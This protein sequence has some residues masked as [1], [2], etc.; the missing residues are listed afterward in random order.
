MFVFV[1]GTLQGGCN[2]NGILRRSKFVS[3][4]VVRGYE[5]YDSG[6][7]V[8]NKSEGT[9]VKGEVWDIGDPE[10]DAVA[11]ATLYNLDSLEG[12]HEHNLEGSMYHR[13]EVLAHAEDGTDYKAGMYLGNK[14]FWRDFFGMRHCP[15][16]D[17]NKTFEW[18]RH[19]RG[20]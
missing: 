5:L 10:T 11:A 7:P 15:Y 3:P 17:A 16:D 19:G 1:Y 18:A 8:A 12:Y 13:V 6:F 20:W 14:H 9:C 2:N 4:A